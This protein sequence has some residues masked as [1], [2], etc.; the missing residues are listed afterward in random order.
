MPTQHE[1]TQQ[2]NALSEKVALLGQSVALQ[3]EQIKAMTVL[4]Q[5]SDK[6]IARIQTKLAMVA[7]LSSIAGGLLVTFAKSILHA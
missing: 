2:V 7:G 6:E 5:A 1:L 4:A 3:Q